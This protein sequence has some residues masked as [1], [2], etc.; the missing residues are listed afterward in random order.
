MDFTNLFLTQEKLDNHISKKHNL[1]GKSLLSE[2]LLALQV[3][4]AELANE[5]MFQILSTKDLLLKI[6]Y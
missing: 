1:S 6:Q 4:I 5:Q 2:K 3:E